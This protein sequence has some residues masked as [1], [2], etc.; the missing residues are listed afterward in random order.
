MR[1]NPVNPILITIRPTCNTEKEKHDT[2]LGTK[3]TI[4]RLESIP[5][6]HFFFFEKRTSDFK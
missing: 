4:E 3:K 5:N 6:V 1:L 2:K